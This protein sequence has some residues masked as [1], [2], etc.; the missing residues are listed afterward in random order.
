MKKANIAI[1]Y[2]EMG[3]PIIEK[4]G[5]P[6]LSFRMSLENPNE[7]YIEGNQDGLLP[8][9]KALLGMAEYENCDD[10]FHIHLDDLYEISN[11]DKTFIISKSK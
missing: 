7:L 11:A 9:A 2:N 6:K 5:K 3:F 10:G 8:L 1:E 4:L